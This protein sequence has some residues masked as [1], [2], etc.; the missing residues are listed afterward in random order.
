MSDQ[1][2]AQAMRNGPRWCRSKMLQAVNP[3]HV[4][5]EVVEAR[6]QRH[7]DQGDAEV[8]RSVTPESRPCA[9]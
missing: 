5:S 1:G 2:A 4:L 9:A 7:I 8:E 3:E 6:L